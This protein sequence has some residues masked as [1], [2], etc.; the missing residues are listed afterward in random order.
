MNFVWGLFEKRVGDMRMDEKVFLLLIVVACFCLVAYAMSLIVQIARKMDQQESRDQKMPSS[1]R[2][3]LLNS[4]S[5][6]GYDG[7]RYG[8]TD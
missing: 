4:E 7:P 8:H 1:L 2:A 6:R 5:L 3:S